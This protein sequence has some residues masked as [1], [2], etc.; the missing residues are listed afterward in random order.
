M[1]NPWYGLRFQIMGRLAP[2]AIPY[3]LRYDAGRG[4]DANGWSPVLL[5]EVTEEIRAIGRHQAELEYQEMLA[6]MT[7][8]E[9]AVAALFKLLELCRNEHIPVMP[10]W[11]PEGTTFRAMYAPCCVLLDLSN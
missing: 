7:L 9:P 10:V 3:Y 11:M 8:G 4:T 2:S 5:P 6:G 1:V